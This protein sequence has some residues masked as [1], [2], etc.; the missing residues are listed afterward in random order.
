MSL[1]IKIL[2]LIC[3]ALNIADMLMQF[4]IPLLDTSG[5]WNAGYIF[6][7]KHVI[8]EYLQSWFFFDLIA[9]MPYSFIEMEFYPKTFL[10]LMSM[11]MIRVRKA[12]NGIKKLIRKMG[13]GVVSV[14]FIISCWNLL[15][16]LHLTACIWGTVGQVNLVNGDPDNWI[17]AAKLQD[18]TNPIIRYI[19]NLYWAAA[20][21]MTVGCGDI[22][23]KNDDELVVAN[24]VMLLGIC[25]FTYNLSSLAQQ[26]AEIIKTTSMR[27]EQH[28][29]A[30]EYLYHT[31]NL[32]EKLIHKIE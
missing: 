18:E 32:D 16:M 29:W 6:E 20:T 31:P 8:S 15:M 10:V 12:H 14:R 28:Q 17:T 22:V 7:R 1:T 4:A 26:F 9:N 30:I 3:D 5:G 2:D 13:F 27:G 23:P 11:K 19:N 21:I 24:I 25:V